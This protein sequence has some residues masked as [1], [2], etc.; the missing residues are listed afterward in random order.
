MIEAGK[1]ELRGD[2]GCWTVATAPVLDPPLLLATL[3]LDQ[4]L[5]LVGNTS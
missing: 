4:F 5:G 1:I 2:T 3:N